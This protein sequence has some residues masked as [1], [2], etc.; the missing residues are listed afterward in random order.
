MKELF[1][2]LNDEKINF[3]EFEESTLTDIEKKSIKKRIKKKLHKRRSMPVK[4]LSAVASLTL[5]AIIAVNSNFALANIPIV[6]EK[7]EA[8]VYS[9][10]DTLTDFK[11]IIGDSVKDNGVKVTL[12][13]VILDEGQLLI[14][15]TFYTK[16]ENNDLAYNWFSDIDI[17]IDG[18]KVELGGGGGPQEITESYIHYFWTADIGHMDMH[19]EKTMRI[20]FNDLKRSDSEKVMKG[21]WS[22]KFKASGENLIANSKKIPINH[23]FTLENGQ[24]IEVEELILTPVSS[25]LVYKMSNIVDDVYFKIENEHGEAIQETIGHHFRFENYNRFEALEGGKI[26]IIPFISKFDNSQ[27]YMLTNEIIELD[28]DE[29]KLK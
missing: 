10:A 24:N 2:K 5:M 16:L 21:K 22:F 23:S 17:Y 18:K 28:L 12:N 25:K 20:V 13:E 19:K 9:Q 27:E 26:K 15:S 29:K 3:E 6:G 11:T 14:S 4:T 7:L 8:F 1:E